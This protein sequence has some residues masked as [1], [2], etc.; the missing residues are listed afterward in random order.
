M[1][2]GELD[3]EVKDSRPGV[4]DDVKIP[5]LMKI[6]G[7]NADSQGSGE[8]YKKLNLEDGLD[9]LIGNAMFLTADGYYDNENRIACADIK[10]VKC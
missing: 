7:F 2:K 1:H 10:E 9:S 4:C 3:D 8:F 6:G 5:T